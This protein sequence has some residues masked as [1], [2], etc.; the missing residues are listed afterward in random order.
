MN[1]RHPSSPSLSVELQEHQVP[2]S[3]PS[4]TPVR[5]R[6]PKLEV[7]KFGANIG[8]WQE[9]R[10]SFESAID[11][12]STLAVRGLLVEPARS[13]IAGFALTSANYKAATDDYMMEKM[14]AI[15]RTYINDL[16]NIE[17]IYS[18]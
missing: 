15:Q 17:P 13:A 16:M 7:R 10:D 12:N 4:T 9:F 3:F 14:T 5:A 11:K 6:L 1:H 2:G 8:E 18:E